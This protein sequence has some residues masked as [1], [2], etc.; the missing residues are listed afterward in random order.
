[1]SYLNNSASNLI[2]DNL[3]LFNALNKDKYV[4]DLA[5]GNGRNGLFLL[6]NDIPIIFADKNKMAL[7]T[8]L[9]VAP[10]NAE[11]RY[12]CWEVDFER[13]LKVPLKVEAYSS[14][15]IFNYLHRPLFPAIKA[16]IT[17]GGLIFYE[18]FTEY[19]LNFGR[20]KNLNYL[21]KQ[22]ELLQ[23]FENWEIIHWFE[24]IK[25]APERAVSSVIARKP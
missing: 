15:L 23:E 7:N 24:G 10:P 25:L 20:P 8:I 9:S 19:Q 17:R 16:A 21:L 3:P 13:C 2:V 12:K 6:N 22:N 1:M 14:I 18:T 4:L 11:G 5:C